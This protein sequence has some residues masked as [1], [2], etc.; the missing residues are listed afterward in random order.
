M[1]WTEKNPNVAWKEGP[2]EKMMG[3]TVEKRPI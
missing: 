1:R 2:M 3:P